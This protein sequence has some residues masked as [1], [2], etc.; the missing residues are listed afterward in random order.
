MAT[1]WPFKKKTPK[2]KISRDK[3]FSKVVEYDRK[4]E[5][6]KKEDE[7]KHLKSKKFV[8]AMKLLSKKDND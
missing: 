8:D 2:P 7:E 6:A 3:F 1:P 5:K 4:S